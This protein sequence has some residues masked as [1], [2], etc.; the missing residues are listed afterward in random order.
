MI[1]NAGIHDNTGV[2][3]TPD[4]KFNLSFMVNAFATFIISYR[5]LTEFNPQPARLINLSSGAHGDMKL[6][7]DSSN[8]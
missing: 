5:L 7:L 2:A 1:N 4:N 8:Y 6:K 3:M